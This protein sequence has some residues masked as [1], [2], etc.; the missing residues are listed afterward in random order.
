[1]PTLAAAVGDFAFANESSDEQQAAV[2]VEC[3]R[4]QNYKGAYIL[5]APDIPQ[6]DEL[7]VFFREF[8]E[9]LGGKLLGR[10]TFA[11][12]QQDFAGEIASIG[13][14]APPPDVVMTSACEPEFP[15]FL[16]QLRAA[17]N[18]IPVPGGDASIR[19]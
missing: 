18:T 8:L 16:K 13:N 12:G 9:K 5:H 17:S 19:R 6:A 15:A 10:S 4:E 1:M 2:L 7:T 14:L 3:A 11:P